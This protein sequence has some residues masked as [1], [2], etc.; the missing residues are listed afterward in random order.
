MKV[1]KHWLPP[2]IF[3]SAVVT[4]ALLLLIVGARSPY[5]H[6]N[7]TPAFAARYNRTSEITVGSPQP[8]Q[9]D[10]RL[11]N[12]QAGLAAQGKTLFIGL[13]CASCHGLKGQGGVYAPTIAGTDAA[14][15]AQRT[16]KGSGGMPIFSSLTDDELKA[17]AAYLQSVL[18]S[19]TSSSERGSDSS[20]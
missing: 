1:K 3:G 16:S 19:P 5:T 20:K 17:L 11:L 9:V 12:S 13:G 2:A 14:T 8:I 7:L 6:A 18:G 4:L 15:I 10:P